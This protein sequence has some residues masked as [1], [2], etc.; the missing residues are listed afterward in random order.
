MKQLVL[1]LSLVSWTLFK[2]ISGSAAGP[3]INLMKITPIF[4]R[5]SPL[6]LRYSK[7]SYVTAMISVLY[8]VPE[9]QAAFYSEANTLLLSKS[10]VEEQMEC[11][12]TSTKA[13]SAIVLA[14]MRM[15]P[16]PIYLDFYMEALKVEL[17]REIND[18]FIIFRD[19]VKSFEASLGA[20]IK[21]KYSIQ[22]E[23]SLYRADDVSLLRKFELTASFINLPLAGRGDSLSQYIKRNFYEPS[24]RFYGLSGTKY[25]N[26]LLVKTVKILNTPPVLM[27]DIERVKS[28]QNGTQFN[29]EV[30]RIDKEIVVN[31]VIYLL[32]ATVNFSAYT[33]TYYSICHDV[34]NSQRYQMVNGR[35]FYYLD[36]A[37]NSSVYEDKYAV[38]LVYAQKSQLTEFSLEWYRQ[39]DD[40]P[41]SIKSLLK[42]TLKKGNKRNRD[43][44]ER[45]IIPSLSAAAL[46]TEAQFNKRTRGESESAAERP[47]LSSNVLTT[48]PS[49]QF[50]SSLHSVFMGPKENSYLTSLFSLFHA[51]PEIKQA[52]FT[53]AAEILSNCPN[54]VECAKSSLVVALAVSFAQ[55]KL[56]PGIKINLEHLLFAALNKQMNFI[57][58]GTFV[59]LSGFLLKFFEMIPGNFK[60]LFIANVDVSFYRTVDDG[61]IKNVIVELGSISVGL[62]KGTCYSVA[63]LIQNNFVDKAKPIRVPN[64]DGTMIKGYSATRILNTPKYLMLDLNRLKTVSLTD[65][66]LT[67]VS[68]EIWIDKEIALN[69]VE[70]EI[71]GRIEFDPVT[72]SYVTIVKD[73][74]SSSLLCYE[75]GQVSVRTDMRLGVVLDTRTTLVIYSQKSNEFDEESVT[76]PEGFGQVLRDLTMTRLT[77]TSNV[78]QVSIYPIDLVCKYHQGTY[79][80]GQENY[81]FHPSQAKLIALQMLLGT[82]ASNVKFVTSLFEFVEKNPDR[83]VESKLAVVIV[84]MLFGCK[85]ISLKE[86]VAEIVLKAKVGIEKL[87]YTKDTATLGN[88]V[89]IIIDLIDP[90]LIANPIIK[91]VAFTDLESDE[92]I[93]ITNFQVLPVNSANVMAPSVAEIRGMWFDVMACQFKKNRNRQIYKSSAIIFPIEIHRTFNKKRNSFCTEAVEGQSMDF[94]V[95]GFISLTDESGDELVGYFFDKFLSK[96]RKFIPGKDSELM[97]SNDSSIKSAMLTKSIQLFVS[98]KGEPCRPVFSSEIPKLLIDAAINQIISESRNPTI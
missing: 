38:M 40:I 79:Q 3:E 96:Y 82:M 51:I 72:S 60:N 75:N 70:Y 93:Q 36:E 6:F 4:S 10:S 25:E 44:F 19:F 8:T 88:Q 45:E 1:F 24:K 98:S 63:N 57:F 30:I 34:G 18:Q 61:F 64:V 91:K 56:Q 94:T 81:S 68:Q 58:E 39:F 78:E 14:R 86:L 27:F 2:M 33:S 89:K 97:E 28:L 54:K 15:Y 49:P 16:T 46:T 87:L 7:N 50:D 23:V 21:S 35:F 17:K 71:V 77:E 37:A 22:A 12:K 65:R 90:G 13:S 5:K 11:L 84:R 41:E 85:D 43:D 67:F 59:R 52:F 66:R 26:V 47:S 74:K 76:V 55:M 29:D 20:N 83:S 62:V 80:L 73:P 48:L 53:E 31:G 9:L 42:E 69:N 92:P 32:A 95:D